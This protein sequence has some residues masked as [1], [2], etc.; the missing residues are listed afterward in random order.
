M[1]NL[2]K[3][4]KTFHLN[5]KINW[6]DIGNK[7]EGVHKIDAQRTVMVFRRPGKQ[8]SSETV[9][10]GSHNSTVITTCCT[11][12]EGND[13]GDDGSD[14][15]SV[16]ALLQASGGMVAIS[17]SSCNYSLFRVQSLL[18][19]DVFKT[20]YTLARR[21]FT[22][23]LER[24]LHNSLLFPGDD[25]GEI[26]WSISDTVP[27]K[28]LVVVAGCAVSSAQILVEKSRREIGL[29]LN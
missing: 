17:S 26:T 27:Q 16:R 21:G 7:V 5:R 1:A 23:L 2:V 14:V 12:G 29:E 9:L 28:I 25:D 11:Y 19:V 8:S 18:T 6:V 20:E 4:C 13:G 10:L 24:E 22:A 15:Q 3:T